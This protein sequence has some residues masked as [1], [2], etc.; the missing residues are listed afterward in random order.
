MFITLQYAKTAKLRTPTTSGMPT[1]AGTPTR[2]GTPAAA[3]MPAIAGTP[4]KVQTSG[5]KVIA[6]VGR[7]AGTPTPARTSWTPTTATRTLATA[8]STAA[9][10][11]YID[12]TKRVTSGR[13]LDN[14][15]DVANG[16]DANNRTEVSNSA[17][18]PAQKKS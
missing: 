9:A 16:R 1:K 11:I 13:V 8:G 3:G 4:E 6:V 5:K 18:T 15:V 14:G 2:A 10:D 7:P 17:L 12:T